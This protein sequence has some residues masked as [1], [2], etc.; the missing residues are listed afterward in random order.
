MNMSKKIILQWAQVIAFTPQ[1]ATWCPDW[2]LFCSIQL[3]G[4]S[5]PLLTE[6]DYMYKIYHRL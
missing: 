1:K 6:I 3:S 4:F 5:I 2:L